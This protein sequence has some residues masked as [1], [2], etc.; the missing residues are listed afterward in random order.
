MKTEPVKTSNVHKRGFASMTAERRAEVA[1]MGGKAAH[2]KGTA[3]T[4]TQA[5]AR[6][7]GSKG[8]QATAAAARAAK[9]KARTTVAVAKR[10]S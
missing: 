7:A 1:A 5:E 9:T 8:G 4:F 3:R 2:A 10:K 6:K